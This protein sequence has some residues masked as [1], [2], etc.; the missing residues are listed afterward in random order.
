M[1]DCGM[2]AYKDTEIQITFLWCHDV[3]KMF[4]QHQYFR[5]KCT[6]IYKGKYVF[7]AHFKKK[8]MFYI[9]FEIS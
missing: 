3:Y 7:G 2:F 9:T 8:K 4:V 5:L 1:I 6:W